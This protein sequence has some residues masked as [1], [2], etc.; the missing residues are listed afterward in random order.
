MPSSLDAKSIQ[1]AQASDGELSALLNGTT[2]LQLQPVELT[3]EV[4][5]YCDVSTGS[6]RPYIPQSLR[7]RIFSH[8]HGLSHP[9]G[10]ATLKQIRHK[11]VWPSMC[12]DVLSWSRN[13]LSCQK[14]KIHK[15]NSLLPEKI[16]IPDHRFEHVHLDIV[17]MPLVDGYRYCLTMI[18]RFSRWPEAVPL[19]DMTAETVCRAFWNCWIARFGCPRIIT[20][21]QGT[22]F[23]SALFKS[24]A[25]LV[26]SSHIHTTPYHPQ[27]NGMIERW[28]RSLKAALM[29]DSETPWLK[30]LPTALLGLRTCIKEDLQASAAEML[31]GCTLHLPNDYFADLNSPPRPAEFVS[32]FRTSMQALKP[33]SAAHHSKPKLFIHKHIHE[34]SHVFVR[35]DAVKQP[36]QPPYSG[37]YQVID[38]LSDRVFVIRMNGKDTSISVDRL[39]PAYLESNDSS[40]ETEDSLTTKTRCTKTYE[41]RV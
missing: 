39:K 17:I 34:C 38:K 2:S 24:L 18:D 15:H 36:L 14:A 7:H 10:R 32:E 13:C 29:C 22:Q 37:P 30:V 11:Y 16:A 25:N 1:E 9:S 40:N 26:G 35:T 33:I 41:R 28:H 21:D 8:V 27:S 31:Y 12:K 6:V 19:R 5:V 3:K 20:T 23:E 4:F